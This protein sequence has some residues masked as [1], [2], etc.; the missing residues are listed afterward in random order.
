MSISVQLNLYHKQV[1]I[2]GGGNVALRKCQQYLNEGAQVTV[3]AKTLHKEFEDKAIHVIQGE[4]EVSYLQHKFLVYAATDDPVLN[5][6]ITKLCDL[7][8]ILCG[9]ATQSRYRSFLSTQQYHNEYVHLALSTNEV[10]VKLSKEMIE[11]GGEFIM[12]VYGN[13]LELLHE[14]K[15]FVDEQ[16]YS[17]IRGMLC[18]FSEDKLKI[19]LQMLKK[20][21]V[22]ILVYH[23]VADENIT[24]HDTNRFIRQIENEQSVCISCVA[25]KNV[26]TYCKEHL[27]NVFL[28][29]E[30]LELASHCKDIAFYFDIVLIREGRYF[31]K[32]AKR[33]EGIGK[34]VPFWF[35]K[36][37]KKE[38][39]KHVCIR[40]NDSCCIFVLHDFDEEFHMIAQQYQGL[41]MGLKDEIPEVT[42]QN[43]H[44]I[45][46][47]MSRG[48]HFIDDVLHKDIGIYARLASQNYHITTEE[49]PIME[50]QWFIDLYKNRIAVVSN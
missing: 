45:P 50:Q 32:L 4:F 29:D 11:K 8:G 3:V 16:V 14:I 31:H 48:S 47:F 5:E 20:K 17:K 40:Y 35:Q 33:C 26:S 37:V 21:K 27:P 18:L 25:S 28:F 15:T 34:L 9:S 49:I 36:E 6:H 46:V 41:C 22:Y 39:I 23:G 30:V 44:L 7:Y 10:A 2:V 12:K 1:L 38:Y 13:K 24:V 43:I 19:V 42:T